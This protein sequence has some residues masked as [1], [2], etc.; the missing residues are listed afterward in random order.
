MSDA[1]MVAVSVE[2]ETNVVALVALLNF[3]ID[4]ATKFVPFTVSVNCEPPSVVA[5]GEILV[6]VG[7][8]F[9][10]LAVVVG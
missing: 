4:D 6:V 9:V 1:R 2:L 5:V 7:I 10:M 8:G 3:T